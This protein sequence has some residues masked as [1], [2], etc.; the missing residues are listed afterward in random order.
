M[1]LDTQLFDAA[2]QKKYPQLC[3]YLGTLYGQEAWRRGLGPELRAPA[4]ACSLESSWFS[5]LDTQSAVLAER[6]HPQF[7][8]GARR[9][10]A[11]VSK[12]ASLSTDLN[13]L[14]CPRPVC[15]P[16]CGG[17][18][19]AGWGDTQRVHAVSLHG[20][21]YFVFHSGQPRQHNPD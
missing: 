17:G 19:Q 13:R 10:G 14:G 20:Y 1:W 6:I 21:S 3:R 18:I 15:H 9:R 7:W 4:K 12:R 11:H 8:S 16:C 5:S 2:A